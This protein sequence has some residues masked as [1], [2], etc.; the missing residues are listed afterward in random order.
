MGGDDRV[1]G[2]RGGYAVGDVD[3]RDSSGGRVLSYLLAVLAACANAASSVLQRKANRSQPRQRTLNW[4]LVLGLLRRPVWLGGVLAV[5]AGFVLQAAALAGGDLAAVQP[6]LVLELPVTLALS[7]LVFSSRLRGREWGCALA[8]TGSVAALLYLLAP[9]A[10][11]AGRLPW[12][13]WTVGLGANAAVVLALAGWARHGLARQSGSRPAALLGAAGGALFGMT[14][15]LMKG[16]TVAF[17][18]GLLAGLTAWQLYGMIAA[19]VAA[20]FL[21]QVAMN[22]GRLIATQPGLTLA[23]PIVALLWG[24]LGFHERVRGGWLV[25]PEVACAAVLGVSVVVLA[26]SPVLSAA[27]RPEQQ[28]EREASCADR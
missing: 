4:R 5:M 8:M 21:V 7:A 16:A 17:G 20:M 19:G 22:T 2:V 23:D 6:V 24:V 25:V 28:D 11:P 1:E 12:Y 10:G 13:A 3:R 14:A 15:A 26:R 27:D 9:S 18:G